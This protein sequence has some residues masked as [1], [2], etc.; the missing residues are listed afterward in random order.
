VPFIAVVGRAVR[1]APA[2]RGTVDVRIG[3]IGEHRE[4]VLDAAART[5][6]IVTAQARAHV[7]AGHATWWGADDVVA[8]T[9]DE[10]I[11]PKPN[12]DSVKV[13]RFWA[14]ADVRVKFRDVRALAEWCLA[15]AQ[16]D[17]VTLGGVTWTLTEKTSAALTASVRTEAVHD[18]ARRAQAYADA[19]ALGPVRL[20]AIFEDGLRPHVGSVGASG[21]V[22]S[23]RSAAA[24][25][26]GG[27]SLDLKPEDIEVSAVVT[28]DFTAGQP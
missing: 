13:R 19:L 1:H 26:S 17:G 24:S 4:P 27:P 3:V 14:G 21:A 16:L 11:K 25:S 20:T 5:H 23:M 8:S 18:A 9:R 28:A 15:V 6:G 22:V 10:W 7:D 2:E 12:Q